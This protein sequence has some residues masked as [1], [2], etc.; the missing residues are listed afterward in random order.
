MT[1]RVE[2]LA[3]RRRLLVARSAIERA[4][5]RQDATTIGNA[6]T[7]VDRAVAVVQRLRRSPLL[8]AAVVV[9]LV[10]FRR[11]PVAAWVMRGLAVAGT[12][13]RLGTTLHRMAEEPPPAAAG[14]APRD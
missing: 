6:L 12:A 5:I 10:A 13:R 9:G 8:I 3:T 4:T 11:H 1:S 2:Q 14:S 7:T